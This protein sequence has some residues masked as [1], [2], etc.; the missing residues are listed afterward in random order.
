MS[1]NFHKSS[2]SD[3]LST[4]IETPRTTKGKVLPRL[5]KMRLLNR[6]S[7]VSSKSDR[8][9]TG[10]KSDTSS[11]SDFG[12]DEFDLDKP[13]EYGL[14]IS[15]ENGKC[16]FQFCLDHNFEAIDP[17]CYAPE[18]LNEMRHL[19]GGGSGVAV[20]AGTHPKLGKIVMKHGGFADLEELFA[21][22]TIEAGTTKHM[23]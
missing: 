20:F 18:C 11:I 5:S 17:D 8:D 7:F 23:R 19:A 13:D 1:E 22:A 9:A 2:S 10:E 21:L 14:M 3:S 12:I 15:V 4:P 6:S 16:E